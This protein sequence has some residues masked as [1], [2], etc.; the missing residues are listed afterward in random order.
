MTIAENTTPVIQFQT[1]QAVVKSKQ[2][3]FNTTPFRFKKLSSHQ[4]ME[5]LATDTSK[6]DDS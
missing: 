6:A 4:F 3:N 1:K 5:N 2:S